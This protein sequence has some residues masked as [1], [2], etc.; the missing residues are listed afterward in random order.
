MKK[1]RNIYT[2]IEMSK[3]TNMSEEEQVECIEN[4]LIEL[5]ENGIVDL[6]GFDEY[7]QPLFSLRK[8]NNG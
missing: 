2:D 5:W 8:Q 7:K 6:V 4:A 1:K 3:F